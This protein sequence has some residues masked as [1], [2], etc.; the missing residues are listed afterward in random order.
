MPAIFLIA[1]GLTLFGPTPELRP[2]VKLRQIVVLA[3]ATDPEDVERA[4]LKIKDAFDKLADGEE[5][6]GKLFAELW[7]PAEAGQPFFGGRHLALAQEPFPLI[8]YA[9]MWRHHPPILSL[10]SRQTSA[11]ECEPPQPVR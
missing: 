4:R 9:L 3:N 5:C 6:F 1:V 2:E 11:R 10:S 7:F 8:G